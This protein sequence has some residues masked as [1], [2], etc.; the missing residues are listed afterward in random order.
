M[1]AF[2]SAIA[3]GITGVIV[4][5]ICAVFVAAFPLGFVK[6]YGSAVFHGMNMAAFI[7]R[8]QFT[9]FNLLLGFVY[10]F[11]TGFVIGGVFAWAY[12][13]VEKSVK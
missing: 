8:P 11:L 6:S 13:W 7:V 12:N 2:S 9:A 4:S 5:A 1:K 10:A 3:G